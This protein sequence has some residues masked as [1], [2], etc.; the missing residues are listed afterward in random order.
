MR[1]AYL[2]G[3]YPRA[4]DTFIQ[5]EVAALRDSGV[6]V[7]TFSVRKPPLDENVGPER[8]AE[9]ERTRYILPCSPIDLVVSI[10]RLKLTATAR[11]F[12][13]LRLAWRVRQPG[14]RGLAYALFYF[15]EACLLAEAMR[16]DDLTHLHNHFG[17]SSCTVAML[18]AELGGF[19]FSFSLHGP[20]IFFEP[21]RWRLDEKCRR[22]L[23]VSNISHF[24][25]SQAMIF[26]PPEKW[27][28]LHIVH[29][30]VDPDVFSPAEHTGR[31][32]R[33]LIVGRMASVKGIP[34]LLDAIKRLRSTHPDL[35]LTV[36]GDGPERASFEQHARDLGIEACIDFVGYQS[37]AEVRKRLCATD[38]FVLPS[39]AEGVPVVLMEAMAAGV[40]VVATRIAGVAELVDDGR[41]GLLVPPGDTGALA[42]AID[43]LLTDPDK[44]AA[45][46]RAG[47][48]KVATEFNI[49]EESAWLRTVMTS[50]LEGRVEAVRPEASAAQAEPPVE[51]PAQ[52]TAP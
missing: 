7:Q 1:I 49:A 22:A 13:A 27:D 3:Q 14:L 6:H 19:T 20:G 51:H 5:R 2:T 42:A 38:V 29:C 33:L 50:A 15:C 36:V 31:G 32:K 4:T 11:Y 45:F 34:V 48:E 25:R 40:P 9:R 21:H 24:C 37:Q 46:G 18:A 8:Q 52:T 47:R 35:N 44:R 26:C 41:S 12:R 10:T 16:K 28:R 23:F 43:E 39:F 30:G 17:D